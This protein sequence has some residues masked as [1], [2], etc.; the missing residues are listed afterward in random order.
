MIRKAKIAD[1]KQMQK[2]INNYADEKRMLSRSLNDIYE[3]IRDFF[4]Y[5]DE[6][7]NIQGCC[8]VHVVWSDLAEIKAMAVA[9]DFNRQGIARELVTKCMTEAKN[10][11]IEKVFALTYVDGFFTKLG[12]SIIK[13]DDLPHKVWRECIHCPK[14]PDCDEIAVEKVL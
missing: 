11:G 9:K 1:V 13:R 3:H 2:L 4:V 6:T 14:F 12:F 7:G 5:E 8:A 10:L